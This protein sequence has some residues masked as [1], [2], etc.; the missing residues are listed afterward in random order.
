MRNPVVPS[1]FAPDLPQ[2]LRFYIETL[3][4][5]QTG[6]YEGDDGGEIWAEVTL[7]DARIWLF[8][9]PLKDQPT[10]SLSGLLYLLVDDVDAVAERLAGNVAFEWGPEDQ[11]Y[12]LRELGI[13]DVNGYNLVFAK[14]C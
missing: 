3:G 12:G 2:T 8:S 6:K 9:Q 7:G 11:D 10:P 5:E 14:D 4:F 1:L 13:K